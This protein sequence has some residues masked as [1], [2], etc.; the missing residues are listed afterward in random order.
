LDYQCQALILKTH[1]LNDADKILHLYSPDQGPLRA[2]AKSAYK[3][4]NQFSS[5]AQVLN[6]GNFLLAKGR[7]LDVVKEIK[8][9]RSFPQ[10]SSN[11]EALMAAY[12]CIDVIDQIAIEDD[13]YDEPFELLLTA[14]ESLEN[15]SKLSPETIVCKFLWDLIKLLGY[16]PQLDRCYISL[17][18][19]SSNQIPQ[20]FDFE[21]GSIISS[22]SYQ[23]LLDED[24]YYESIKKLNSTSFRVLND[25]QRGKSSLEE[26]HMQ[27]DSEAL[28]SC[29]KFLN[30]HLGYRL[31][32]E[33]KAWKTFSAVIDKK[34]ATV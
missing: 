24:P 23:A 7:S 6:L 10:I 5:K 29:L 19:R 25:L 34:I 18:E 20:Y 4:N 15:L 30:Q 16:Q 12:Y 14:L 33:V 9:L 21:N 17:K 32:K 13:H 22:Q 11:Y 27:H 1:R 2:V 26:L 3:M 31:Y 8:L 28:V